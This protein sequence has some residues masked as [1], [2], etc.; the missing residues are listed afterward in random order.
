MPVLV[1]G[2]VLAD[3]YRQNAKARG[4]A[5]GRAAA[6]LL[7]LVPPVAPLLELEQPLTALPSAASRGDRVAADEC[8]RRRRERADRAVADPVTFDGTVVFATD[9]DGLHDP[10][11]DEE[12]DAAHGAGQRRHYAP[13]CG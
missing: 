11:D 12:L 7:G 3:T 4:V 1:L 2:L 8:L 5:V 10:A 6:G 9:N 13:R